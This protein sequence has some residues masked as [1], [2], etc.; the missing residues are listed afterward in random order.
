MKKILDLLAKKFVQGII[1]NFASLIVMTICGLLMNFLISS[2]FNASIYGVFNQVYAIYLVASQFAVIGIHLSVLKHTAEYAHAGDTPK[3][4]LQAGFLLSIICS[5]VTIL[6]LFFTRDLIGI[7]LKSDEI[8][9][10]ILSMLPALFFF[11]INKVCLAYLNGQSRI[12]EYSIFQGMRYILIIASLLVLIFLKV[13]P[14]NLP[15]IFSSAELFVFLFLSIK[16]KELRHFYQFDEL[17]KWAKIHLSFG[18]RSFL[19]NVLLDLNTRADILILGIMNTDRVVGIY[20]LAVILI[21]G[22]FQIPA[23]F[24]VNY[25]PIIVNLIKEQKWDSLRRLVRTGK[26]ITYSLMVVIGAACAVFFPVALSF[27]GKNSDFQASYIP[28]LILLV[29]LTISS[30]YLPFSNIILQAGY[31]GTHT[32]MIFLQVSLNIALNILFASRLGAVGSALATGMAMI[33]LIPLVNIFSKKK[34]NFTF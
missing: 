27:Y 16:L 15:A 2:K 32:F 11:S 8:G 19:S 13:S 14:N 20:S 24:R 7:I 31:P 28:F 4:I 10:G 3:V 22:L 34:I 9:V 18:A 12:K 1:W 33:L 5:L 25:S 23:A 30:G 21:D 29:S 17:K 26:R 6:V